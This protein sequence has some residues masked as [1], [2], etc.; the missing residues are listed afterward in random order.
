MTIKSLQSTSLTNNIFY[1][2]MLAGNAA[3]LPAVPAF[4]LLETTTLATATSSVTF[5]GLGSYASDYDHLQIRLFARTNRGSSVDIVI[6]TLNGDTGSNYSWHS[7]GGNGGAVEGT[8]GSS[9]VKINTVGVA[10]G[11]SAG[12]VMGAGV[13][14]ILDFGNTSKNT[15]VT[16]LGGNTGGNDVRL[17]SGTWFNTAAVTSITLDQNIG[18]TFD[19]ASRFSLYGIKKAV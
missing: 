12:D 15:T 6:M 7:L 9:Q 13:L 14:D 8:G 19:G 2:S 3:Y 11:T 17:I 10:A 5:S 1:R 18:T 4:D 16:G